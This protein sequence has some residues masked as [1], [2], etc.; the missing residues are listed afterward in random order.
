[1]GFRITHQ[2]LGV[3]GVECKVWGL[4]VRVQVSSCSGLDIQRLGVEVDL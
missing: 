1:M 4:G 2:G 3:Q